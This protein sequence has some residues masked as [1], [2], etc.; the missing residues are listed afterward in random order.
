MESRKSEIA[1]DVVSNRLNKCGS[2]SL[3]RQKSMPQLFTR[4]TF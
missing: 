2:L 3:T 1:K 4:K